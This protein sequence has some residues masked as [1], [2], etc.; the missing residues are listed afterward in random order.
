MFRI[1]VLIDTSTPGAAEKLLFTGKESLGIPELSPIAT[2]SKRCQNL[3][4]S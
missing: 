4:T 3:Q 1:T 2:C